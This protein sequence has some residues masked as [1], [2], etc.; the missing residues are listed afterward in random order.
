MLGVAE[1]LNMMLESIGRTFAPIA[2]F[3]GMI[4]LGKKCEREGEQK[5]QGLV[6]NIHTLTM[7]YLITA[8]RHGAIMSSRVRFESRH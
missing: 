8:S 3:V 6:E 4:C 2:S 7:S 1:T 5:R